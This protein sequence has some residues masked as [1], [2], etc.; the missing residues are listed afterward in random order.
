L[1][2]ER[3]KAIRHRN[4]FVRIWYSGGADSHT[5]LK[6]FE[7][8][9]LAPDEIVFNTWCHRPGSFFNNNFELDRAV[10]PYIDQL[11]QWFPGTRIIQGNI[12]L[13]LLR[14]LRGL[15]TDYPTF[16]LEAGVRSQPICGVSALFDQ[17]AMGPGI[18]NITGSDKP[19]LDLINGQ[20]YAWGTDT[21]MLHSWGKYVEGF[22]QSSDPTI[23]IRQCH[24]MK[25]Y[26]TKNLSVINRQTVLGSQV[27]KQDQYTRRAVN[28]AL[29]R[30]QPFDNSANAR[31]WSKRPAPGIGETHPKAVLLY[32]E[33]QRTPEGP[34]LLAEWERRKKQFATETG[35][36]PTVDV[37]GR[38]YNLDTGEIHTVDQLFP[39]GWH[40]K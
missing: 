29:G 35:Y 33:L 14:A 10:I 24:D 37:F 7:L 20:W 26:L 4:Q 38:F 40:D 11:K 6:S 15:H 17:L 19:R 32:R 28:R 31:K 9:G 23:F 22:F 18:V 1:L 2:I 13:A 27:Y 5:V 36:C 21:S 3:A 8:A 30:H 12:D 25:N 16:A 39:Q 34:E